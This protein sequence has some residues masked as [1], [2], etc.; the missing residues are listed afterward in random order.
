M[1]YVYES[2]YILQRTEILHYKISV[3][4]NDGIIIYD[5][6]HIHQIYSLY[7]PKCFIFTKLVPHLPP[8]VPS[9][10][11][12]F[13]TPCVPPQQSGIENITGQVYG[14]ITGRFFI[15]L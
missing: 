12:V 11:W 13:F 5:T 1:K 3:I 6:I 2:K 8:C 14:L 9:T 4:L 10:L 15:T 7:I